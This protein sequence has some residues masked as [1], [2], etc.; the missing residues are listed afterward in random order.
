MES[1]DERVQVIVQS[2]EFL[3]E[4]EKNHA[5]KVV[6]Q[7]NESNFSFNKLEAVKEVLSRFPGICP[8]CL[9]VSLSNQEVLVEAGP[10]F[11]VEPCEK[12]SAE[13]MSL[14]GTGSV[15]FE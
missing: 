13:L 11:V 9:S 5:K 2:I 12:L 1:S 3:H 15:Y 8:V 4:A 14:V 7:I 6:L 10:N